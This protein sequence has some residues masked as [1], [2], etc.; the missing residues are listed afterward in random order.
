MLDSGS[1]AC[2]LQD[3]SVSRER[4]TREKFP[5]LFFLE[6]KGWK[7]FSR[8]KFTSHF[9]IFLENLGQEATSV[10]NEFLQFR[11]NWVFSFPF[12]LPSRRLLIGIV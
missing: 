5:P 12:L 10:F 4:S 9:S 7:I 2:Q 3:I 8:N 6:E 1:S 11:N